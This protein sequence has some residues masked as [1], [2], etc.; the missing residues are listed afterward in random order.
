[1]VS[2]L[3]YKMEISNFIGLFCLKKPN[4]E[5]TELKT[6]SQFSAILFMALQCQNRKVLCQVFAQAIYLLAKTNL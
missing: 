4:F 5:G 1:M 3:A 2:R 6:R